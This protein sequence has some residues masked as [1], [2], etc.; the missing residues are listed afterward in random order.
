MVDSGRV[1]FFWFSDVKIFSHCSHKKFLISII[2][3]NQ[4]E[5][6]GIARFTKTKKGTKTN[7]IYATDICYI[8]FLSVSFFPLFS[9]PNRHFSLIIYY[10]LFLFS[11]LKF[12]L[13]AS[14]LESENQIKCFRSKTNNQN[15]TTFFANEK[16]TLGSFKNEI[17]RNYY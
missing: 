5:F 15:L 10:N 6:Y 1:T 2:C 16:R 4:N 13:R 3:H 7:T 8:F 12:K 14:V 9:L 17:N 11:Q